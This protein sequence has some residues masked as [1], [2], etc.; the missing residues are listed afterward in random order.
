MQTPQ[1]IAL[2]VAAI[3]AAILALFWWVNRTV[4]NRAE[5]RIGELFSKGA[6]PE[7][8][9][10]QL[11]AEGFDAEHAQRLVLSAVKRSAAVRA[12]EV[13]GKG[14]TELEVREELESNGLSAELAEEVVGEVMLREKLRRR[15]LVYGAL[16]LLGVVV[17]VGVI[18]AGF[19]LRAGNQTGRFPTFPFAGGLTMLVG[20]MI[21]VISI[22]PLAFLLKRTH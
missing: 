21:L 2:G 4:A 12:L 14:A 16:G 22:L 17:G 7:Q 8:V 15:P 20:S 11:A 3:A 13:L 18:F 5:I 1:L 19:V 10:G 6:M 9:V